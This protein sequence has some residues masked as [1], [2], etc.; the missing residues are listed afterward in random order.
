MAVDAKNFTNR[1]I[2]R[3][4]TAIRALL[5][6]NA[7]AR[8]VS[9]LVGG[10]AS[11]QILL[12]LAAPILTRLYTPEDFG[13]LAVYA[14]L[15]ALI[16]VI[17]SLRYERAIP[18]PEDNVEAANVAVL[19]LLLVGIST[20]LTAVLVLMLGT[21]IAELFGVP[22]LANYLWLLPAGVLLSGAYS[23]FTYWS[24]RTKRFSAVAQTKLTQAIAT[25][26]IQ[27]T[28]FKLG[29][30]GLLLGQAVGHGVG[31][32]RLA[33]SALMMSVFKQISW[34]GVWRVA[35]RYRQ[36]PVFSTWGGFMNTASMRLPIV[37]ISGVFSPSVAGLLSIAERVL[38]MPAS[39]I[40]VAIS[41][42]FLSSAPDANRQNELKFLTENVS[43]NLI[44]IGMPPALLIFLAGPELFS[45]VFGEN[46]RLA[47]EFARWM[48][49]WLYFQFISSPLSMIFSV[50]EK[51]GQSLA[52]QIIL[53]VANSFAIF[54]GVLTGDAT[55]T[56]IMLSVANS[57]C[58]LAL[59]LWIAHL[60]KSSIFTILRP[61]LSAAIVAIVCALPLLV[62]ALFF[63]NSPKTIISALLVSVLLVFG[64]Y[65]QLA[66][67]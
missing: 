31:T 66:R 39:L 3:S 2:K 65:Y 24:V 29:G 50:T 48:T 51:M 22:V 16:G 38:Q 45:F 58:Y 37:V 15:L 19:S 13:L 43:S 67:Y 35:S 41:Q 63:E 6:K 53:F 33:R 1:M 7:F 14:S 46:W 25:L 27:L 28:T 32:M 55:K 18:L 12:V 42:V 44:H 36:F 54:V 57:A 11:A 40:G 56:I 49:P 62:V 17:S 52:W 23:V 9:V 26:A 34:G 5:P 10:T 4:K 8:G 64:R 47:G 20:A 21:S 30:I 60:S 61:M 59:L